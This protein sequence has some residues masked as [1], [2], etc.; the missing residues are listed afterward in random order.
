[1]LP[2]V[3]KCNPEYFYFGTIICSTGYLSTYADE[4]ADNIC[5]KRPGK[6]KIL[7]IYF[8]NRK[9]DIIIKEYYFFPL[10]ISQKEEVTDY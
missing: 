8:W 10:P 3:F 4:R 7:D 2:A 5:C 1:M 6:A 9:L